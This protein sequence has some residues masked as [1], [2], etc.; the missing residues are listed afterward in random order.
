MADVQFEKL[1][2]FLRTRDQELLKELN[3]N[4]S[5][6]L[7]IR[8]TESAPLP[9]ET[10]SYDALDGRIVTLDLDEEGNLVGIEFY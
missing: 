9:G 6:P 1:L 4:P 7:Y 10:V 8:F 2:K 3:Y 5:D